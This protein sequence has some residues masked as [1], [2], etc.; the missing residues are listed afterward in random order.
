MTSIYSME[1][2]RHIS[3]LS[4]PKAIVYLH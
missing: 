1:Y 3:Y 2:T 4:D